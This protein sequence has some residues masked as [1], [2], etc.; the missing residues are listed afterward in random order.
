MPMIALTLY[1]VSLGSLPALP[2]RC[3]ELAPR[4]DGTR[5]TV[6]GGHVVRVRDGRGNSREFDPLTGTITVRSGDGTTLVLAR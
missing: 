1:L 6:C 3:E 2:A 5:V 4:L